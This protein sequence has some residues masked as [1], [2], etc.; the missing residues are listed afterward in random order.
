MRLDGLYYEKLEFR[1]KI[2]TVNNYT[3]RICMLL[4]NGIS[5]YLL[6]VGRI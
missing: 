4:S 2:L 1:L 6:F 3:W 5:G